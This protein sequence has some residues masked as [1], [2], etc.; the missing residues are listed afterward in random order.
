VGRLLTI[1][2]A[3]AVA[4]PGVVAT[5]RPAA[6]ASDPEQLI[7]DLVR[8]EVVTGE[9]YRDVRISDVRI[10]PAVEDGAVRY[11]LSAEEGTAPLGRRNFLLLAY[12]GDG[13]VR[14]HRVNARV[15]AAVT[16]YYLKRSVPPGGEID[17]SELVASGTPASR[18]PKGAVT[19]PAELRGMVAR[20]RIPA[21]AV[22]RKSHLK[23]RPAVR[24]GERVVLV[25]ETGGVRVTGAGVALDEAPLQSEVKVRS[26]SSRKE[27]IGW[28][29][30]PGIVRV[31]F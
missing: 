23:P 20:R 16:V 6:S 27:I 24:R 31:V 25:A 8:D 14:A 2:L 1:V 18:V 30:A 22:L 26:L 5:P 19:D 12:R 29:E 7:R 21:N 11:E 17:P 4:V 10:Q 9:G 13:T 3:L 15:E 28:L